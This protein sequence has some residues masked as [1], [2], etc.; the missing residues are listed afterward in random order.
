MDAPE[1]I[2]IIK[3]RMESLK[4]STSIKDTSEVTTT[5]ADMT[6]LLANEYEDLLKE[7][8]A[9]KD[10]SSLTERRAVQRP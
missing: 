10:P 5:R 6:Q 4:N 1:I 7:I 8:G 3:R 9:A 2:T